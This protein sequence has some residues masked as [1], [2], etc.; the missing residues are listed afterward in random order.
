M[1]I[2][3]YDN[4][5]PL[6]SIPDESQHVVDVM[7]CMHNKVI[8]DEILTLRQLLYLRL[9]I[10]HGDYHMETSTKDGRGY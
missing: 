10:D 9:D 6:I 5:A 3:D 8:T 2:L 7:R 1:F 4:L